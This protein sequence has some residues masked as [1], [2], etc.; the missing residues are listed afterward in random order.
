MVIR[1]ALM[2]S[3]MLVFL[4]G[5]AW[6]QEAALVVENARVIVGD[7]TVME[8]G[9][10]AVARDRIVTVTEGLVEAP[11][12]RRI[13]AAGKTVL[14]GLIDAHVHVAEEPVTGDLGRQY[15]A[16]GTTSIRDVGGPLDS[17]LAWRE[18]WRTGEHPGPRLFIAG[19]PLDGDPPNW[20]YPGIAWPVTRVE[21]ARLAVGLQRRL[22]VD[23]VKLYSALEPEVLKAAIEAAHEQKLPVTADLARYTE[24]IDSVFAWG[25]DSF[26]HGFTRCCGERVNHM[27]RP[28]WRL[29]RARVSD[30]VDLLVDQDITLVSTAIISDRLIR[31]EFPPD[32]PTYRALPPKLQEASRRMWQ[33]ERS[34]DESIKLLDNLALGWPDEVCGPVR[35]FV[36]RGGTLA[37]GTDSFFLA[38]YPGDAI[39]EAEFHV[40][41]GLRPATILA[42]LTRNAAELLD[43]DEKLGTLEAGMLADLIVVDGNPLDDIS[44]LWNIELVVK[45]GE[46]VVEN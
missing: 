10:V 24:S 7:G 30:L 8:R 38:A 40:E 27:A 46:V 4:A 32:T 5:S 17:L 34:R 23:F 43:R 28:S 36:E 16:F 15:L 11:D 6:A 31:G 37:F 33:R 18:R 45:G 1:G 44:A 2:L 26:E 13:D 25:L 12:A 20:P 22:G 35:R 39:A 19:H 9:S 21:E 41:C 3:G 14:P 29:D 42:A